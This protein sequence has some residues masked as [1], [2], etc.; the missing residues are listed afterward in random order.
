MPFCP[1]SHIVLRLMQLSSSSVHSMVH[2]KVQCIS[3]FGL[4]L[5]DPSFSPTSLSEHGNVNL[6]VSKTS[7][8]TAQSAP[9]TDVGLVIGT[10]PL[11]V[12]DMRRKRRTIGNIFGKS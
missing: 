1:F 12:V 4:E 5:E 2:R 8:Q 7:K 9:S 6:N 11:M 10:N 3:S